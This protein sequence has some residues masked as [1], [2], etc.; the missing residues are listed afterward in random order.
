MQHNTHMHDGL[1][2]CSC[3][4]WVHLEGSKYR[5]DDGRL[6]YKVR[7]IS[8]TCSRRTRNYRSKRTAKEAWNKQ[9]RLEIHDPDI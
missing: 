4:S 8:T 7:C 1:I 3:H 6:E 5:L 2:S 9:R